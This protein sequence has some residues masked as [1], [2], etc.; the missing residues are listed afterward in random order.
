[1][2]GLAGYNYRGA[3]MKKIAVVCNNIQEWNF[4][5]ETL[6]WNLSKQ[7]LPYARIP[8]CFQDRSNKISYCLVENNLYR[9]KEA[10]V[11]YEFEQIVWCCKPDEGVEEYLNNATHTRI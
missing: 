11:G 9:A 8:K 1:M 3:G 6:E 5:C 2:N 10:T 7:N 4:F